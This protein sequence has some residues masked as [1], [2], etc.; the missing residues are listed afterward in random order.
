MKLSR[1]FLCSSELSRNGVDIAWD[2]NL[3]AKIKMITAELSVGSQK[4]IKKEDT[5]EEIFGY[6]GIN[7]L[8]KHFPL[9]GYASDETCRC[10][11]KSSFLTRRSWRNWLCYKDPKMGIERYVMVDWK[12]LDILN[13]W[14]KNK[15]AFGKYH[16][17]CLI[18]AR[19]LQLHMDLD[20]L[21]HILIIPTSS[22]TG[23]DVYLALFWDYPEECK[24]AIESFKWSLTLPKPTMKV[25][26]RRPFLTEGRVDRSLPMRCF[27]DMDASAGEL[28]G[29]FGISFTRTRNHLNLDSENT[30]TEQYL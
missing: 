4:T 15:N 2:G 12:V 1:N 3:S 16:H 29:A 18:Y 23:K 7:I 13:S 14:E 5:T 24:Q 19:L 27:L 6:F 9:Y 30:I 26:G 25:R 21:P 10:I 11:A 22:I 17:Q 20:Y 8:D 28:L